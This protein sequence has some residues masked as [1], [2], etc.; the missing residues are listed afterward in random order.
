MIII[1]HLER[2]NGK[3]FS[4]FFEQNYLWYCKNNKIILKKQQRSPCLQRI[5]IEHWQLKSDDKVNLEVENM[6]IFD[7]SFCAAQ[8]VDC[9]LPYMH[10]G[11]FNFIKLTRSSIE[12]D[13]TVASI[14]RE[15]AFHIRR[16]SLINMYDNS[17]LIWRYSTF[18]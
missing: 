13:Q 4:H 8:L 15:R 18:S 5:G 10:S 12:S 7:F 17:P 9:D 3:V 16:M 6:I 1:P 14:Q 11:I 2:L